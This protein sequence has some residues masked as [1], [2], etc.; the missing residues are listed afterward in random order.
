[1]DN[2]KIKLVDPMESVYECCEVQASE[3]HLVWIFIIVNLVPRFLGNPENIG[4]HSTL[5][6]S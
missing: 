5:L 3:F 1:M 4:L 6:R 2:Q